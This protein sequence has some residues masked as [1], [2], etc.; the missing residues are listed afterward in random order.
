[1]HERSVFPRMVR[2]VRGGERQLIT[3]QITLLGKPLKDCYGRLDSSPAFDLSSPGVNS[4][5]T[6]LPPAALAPPP[7]PLA[8][9]RSD[10][11]PVPVPVPVEPT[12]LLNSPLV[13]S[14]AA[15]CGA[16]HVS[17]IDDDDDAAAFFSP[18]AP[19]PGSAEPPLLLPPPFPF[20]FLPSG[21]CFSL[22]AP[23]PAPTLLLAAAAAA[24]AAARLA[25]LLLLTSPSAQSCPHPALGH[26]PCVV[27]RQSQASM[28]AT[29]AL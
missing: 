7:P 2:S 29:W 11:L 27:G 4:R 9:S 20:R 3:F 12:E 17:F 5:T 19:P 6:F 26:S 21:A 16:F 14:T 8:K 18:F 28:Q 10:S 25:T 22:A 15:L 24:A 1:M 13:R 23:V